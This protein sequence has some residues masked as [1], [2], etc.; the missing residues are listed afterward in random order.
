MSCQVECYPNIVHLIRHFVSN[1]PSREIRH[2]LASYLHDQNCML[3][4]PP[5]VLV[6]FSMALVAA[7][8]GMA[9]SKVLEG[10]TGYHQNIQALL[11]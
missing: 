6:V 11:F 1:V 7:F 2:Y 3:M 9:C 10:I 5:D 4:H 8:D